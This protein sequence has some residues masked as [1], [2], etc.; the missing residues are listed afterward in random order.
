MTEK[1]Q[2]LRKVIRE[3]EIDID[4]LFVIDQKP[5]FSFG[6]SRSAGSS[7]FDDATK[8]GSS[9]TVSNKKVVYKKEKSYLDRSYEPVS[10]TDSHGYKIGM[11][12]THADFGP[13]VIRKIEGSGTKAKLDILFQGN[14]IKK[15]MV[16]YA[17]LNVLDE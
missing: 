15:L 14:I 11:Q 1:Y 4:K 17:V 8:S 13:G 10:G 7:K 16:Q 9:Y 12:V 5:A 2:H 3:A 6:S